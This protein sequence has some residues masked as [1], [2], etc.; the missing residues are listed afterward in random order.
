MACEILMAKNDYRK[1]GINW[2]YRFVHR[3]SELRSCFS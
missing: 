1:L 2:V 3:H